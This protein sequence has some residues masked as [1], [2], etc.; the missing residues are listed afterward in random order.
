MRNRSSSIYSVLSHGATEIERLPVNPSLLTFKDEKL[1]RKYVDALF[2]DTEPFKAPSAEFKANLLFFFIYFSLYFL[3]TSVI[4]ILRYLESSTQPPFIILKLVS[5][6]SASTIVYIL[7][8]LLKTSQRL[9]RKATRLISFIA[10]IIIVNLVLTDDRVLAS[11]TGSSIENPS[12][13]NSLLM[14]SFMYFFKRLLFGNFRYLLV[15]AIFA[16]G[17]FASALTLTGQNLYVNMQEMFLIGLF[18]AMLC[19]SCYRLE[20]A[21]RDI[22]WKNENKIDKN[23]ANFS[24]MTEYNDANSSQFINTEVELLIQLCERIKKSVKS[25][26]SM[27]IYKDIKV[28][29]KMATNSLDSL[30]RRIA[31]E[32]FRSSIK[33]DQHDNIDDQDKTFISQFFMQMS[34]K[35][36]NPVRKVITMDEIPERTSRL[37]YTEYGSSS[38]DKILESFGVTWNFDIWFVFQSTGHSVFIAAKYTCTKWGLCEEFS[39]EE[40]VFDKFF[41]SVEKVKNI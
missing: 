8:Y 5:L 18:Y 3:S 9:Y 16:I 38:L 6:G 35:N 25:A 39:I 17:A 10:F 20:F 41:H 24:E 33:L 19:S 13:L 1:E 31:G 14:L 30:K 36:S 12:Q 15:L 7:L 40:E 28:K 22:F 23:N 4:D 27:I 21:S 2:Y 26:Y 11:I 29:L 32:L 34:L 37:C